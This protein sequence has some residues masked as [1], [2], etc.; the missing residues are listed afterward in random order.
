VRRHRWTSRLTVDDCLPLDV[1]TF[2]RAG[3][4]LANAFAASGTMFWTRDGNVIGSIGYEINPRP[5]GVS[6]R[7]PRQSI[8]VDGE[9]RLVEEC[10]MLIATTR[11]YLGGR[12]FWFVCKCGRRF[13]QLYLPPEEQ[14]F[15][16]RICH[17]LTYKSAQK[18]DQR[19]YDLARDPDALDAVF[20]AALGV[21]NAKR[22][23]LAALGIGALALLARRMRKSE[24]LA[25]SG[26]LVKRCGG[27]RQRRGAIR[28]FANVAGDH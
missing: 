23:R 10:V 3:P 14:I 2:H 6:V 25:A 28:G 19:K 9:N 24:W 1:E 5:P 15:A 21:P 26:P 22:V 20:G 13:G 17:N 12:R 16:C 4:A 11:P 18:H 7:I 8:V 27:A